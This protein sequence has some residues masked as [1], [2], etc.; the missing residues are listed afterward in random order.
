MA[1]RN[2]KKDTKMKIIELHINTHFLK[3]S[4][5]AITGFVG[6]FVFFEYV[7]VAEHM[8]PAVEAFTTAVLTKIGDSFHSEG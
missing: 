3:V 8:K 6:C 7:H 5:W 1:P 4:A 2:R